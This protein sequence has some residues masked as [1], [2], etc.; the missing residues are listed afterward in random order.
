MIVLPPAL[1]QFSQ[2]P[3]WSYLFLLL[4]VAI[5]LYSGWSLLCWRRRQDLYYLLM[6]LYLTAVQLP[7]FSPSL[8]RAIDVG[9]HLNGLLPRTLVAAPAV[10][11]FV[12]GVRAREMDQS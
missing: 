10:L 12:L 6:G 5:A 11:L 9:P 1:Q 7:A 3:F 8:G 4:S 2:Q